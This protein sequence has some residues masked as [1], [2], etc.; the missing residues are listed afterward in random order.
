MKTIRV[1][2][3]VQIGGLSEGEPALFSYYKIATHPDGH[4]RLFSQSV[5]VTDAGLVEQLK[6][7]AHEGEEAEI[8]IEQYIGG[9]KPSVLLSFCPIQALTSVTV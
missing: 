7:E 3:K 9:G 8:E 5:Q 6:R 4:R 1:R 2:T